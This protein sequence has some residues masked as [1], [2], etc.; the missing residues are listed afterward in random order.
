VE[1]DQPFPQL[2]AAEDFF[3][4]F[5]PAP[6]GTQLQGW[7][8]Y[9]DANGNTDSRSGYSQNTSGPWN[10]TLPGDI[11]VRA[12]GEVAAYTDLTA[13]HCYNDIQ[14]FFYTPDTEVGF[15]A[16]IENVGTDDVTEYQ[17]KWTVEDDMGTEVFADSAVFGALTAGAIAQQSC[18]SAWTPGASGYYTAFAEV[19]NRDDILLENNTADLEQGVGTTDFGWMTYDDGESSASVSTS[20]GNGWGQRFDP[21]DYPIKVD[22]V[23]VAVDS[24]VGTSDVRLVN[25]IPQGVNEL[26]TYNGPLVSGFNVLDVSGEDINVFEGGIGVSYTYQTSSIYKDATPPIAGPNLQMPWTAYQVTGTVWTPMD[27]G[28]WMLSAYCVES[29]VTP[30]EPDI[31]IEPEVVDFDTVMVNTPNAGSFTVYN[32]G[33]AT[34]D[35]TDIQISAGLEDEIYLFQTSFA[36]FPGASHEVLMS[37]TPNEVGPLVGQLDIINNATEPD[38]EVLPLAGYAAGDAVIGTPGEVPTYFVLEGNYPNPFNNIT[39]LAFALPHATN[40]T[41][42]VYDVNG[43]EVAEVVNGWTV[44]GRY[45]VPFD[46]SELSSGV[47]VYELKAGEFKAT[48]KMVFMK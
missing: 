34:L 43:Q 27:D 16:E 26:W 9:I 38:P 40:V 25:I 19:Y 22:S 31:R 33:E 41:L 35:V 28:D 39:T 36:V 17:V 7:F 48:G 5:G 32:D 23:M 3:V 2:E 6:G 44:A 10:Y 12:G 47:Y 29:S 14:A 20:P 15:E 11:I 37:W 45:E 30:P 21:P 13:N 18:P 24:D 42:K 8:L 1:L 46:A 4:V